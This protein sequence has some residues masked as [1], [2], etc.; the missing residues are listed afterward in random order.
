MMSCCPPETARIPGVSRLAMAITTG[1][2][3]PDACCTASYMY[4]NPQEEV[5]V[6]VRPPAKL[7]AATTFIAEFSPSTSTISVSTM[8]SAR[9]AENC[10]ATSLIGVIG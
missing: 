5:A 3:K 9:N 1:A 2:L 4:T 6:K 10:S 7:A 8:P